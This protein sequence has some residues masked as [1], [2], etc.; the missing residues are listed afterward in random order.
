MS[1]IFLLQETT[2]Y[3]AIQSFVS[4]KSDSVSLVEG[5]RVQVIEKTTQDW[6]FVRKLVTNE[7]GFVPPSVLE[8]SDTY[9]SYMKDTLTKKI[10]KLPVLRSKKLHLYNN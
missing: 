9:T 5:E 7:K 10:E 4:E 6:W 3:V 1:N 8:D 2:E